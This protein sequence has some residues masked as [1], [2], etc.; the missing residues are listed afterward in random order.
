MITFDWKIGNLER[1]V[2]TG[3]VKKIHWSCTASQNGVGVSDGGAK[4]LTP[5]PDAPGFIAYDDLTKE[6]VMGWLHDGD[7]D[8]VEGA[9]RVRLQETLNPSTVTGLPWTNAPVEE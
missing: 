9:L 5:D 8:V 4:Q 1:D 7:K 3:G 6:V 2:A